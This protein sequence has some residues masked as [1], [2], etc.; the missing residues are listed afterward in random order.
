MI[1]VTLNF[2]KNYQSALTYFSG[3]RFQYADDDLE[4][5]YLTGWQM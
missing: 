1:H 3:F 5:S 2:A 4:R